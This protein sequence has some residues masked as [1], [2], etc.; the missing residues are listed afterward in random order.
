MQFGGGGGCSG[1][2]PIDIIPRD[3]VGTV[4]LNENVIPR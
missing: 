4:V 2:R 1:K 3:F